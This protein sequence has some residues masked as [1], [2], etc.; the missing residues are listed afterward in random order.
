MAKRG[1]ERY[2]QA[3]VDRF[4]HGGPELT[5]AAV[6]HFAYC[7]RCI[8]EVENLCREADLAE[9]AKMPCF[10]VD[11]E[12]F[13]RQPEEFRRAFHEGRRWLESIYGT[14]LFGEPG[15]SEPAPKVKR[16]GSPSRSK[17]VTRSRNRKN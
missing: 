6:T 1:C 3:I 16:R 11:D 2:R 10:W 9:M 7:E 5:P 15:D 4:V 14:S 17:S 13:A 8:A 12:M